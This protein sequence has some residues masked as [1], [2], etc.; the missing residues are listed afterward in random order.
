VAVLV[1]IWVAHPAA[2]FVVVPLLPFAA[3]GGA[4]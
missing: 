1:V 3:A 4:S 2:T